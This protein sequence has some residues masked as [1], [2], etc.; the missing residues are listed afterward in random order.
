MERPALSSGDWNASI[1]VDDEPH[2]F[3][4]RAWGTYLTCLRERNYYLS[5]DELTAICVVAKVN[6]MI[7]KQIENALEHAA[8]NLEEEGPCIY[9]KISANR[10]RAVRSHFER[11]VSVDALKRL[12]RR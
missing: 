1:N 12:E 4:S 9:V 6:V 10:K 2:E 7:F 8:S 5:V 3:G 11:L